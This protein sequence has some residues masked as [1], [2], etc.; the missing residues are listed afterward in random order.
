MYITGLSGNEMYC[1]H[2]IGYQAGDIVIGNSVHSLGFLGS[3]T[4]GLKSIAGGEVSQF[5]E[6]IE[7]GRRTSYSRMEAEA[8]TKGGVGITGVRNELIFHS[9]N[10][11]F[12]SIGSSLHTE[13]HPETDKLNFSTS[14]DGQ[15]LFCQVDAGYE[16]LKFVFGNIAYSIGL[17]NSIMGSIKTL[18]KGEIKEYSDIFNTTRKTTLNRIIKEAKEHS[19]KANAVVGIRTNILPLGVSGFQEMVMIGT[20]AYNPYI[21]KDLNGGIVTSDLTCQE[22]WNL[23]KMGYAPVSLVLGTSVYSMGIV[24][25]LSSFFKSFTRGELPQYSKLIYDARENSI[26][27]ISRE[28]KSLGADDIVGVKTYVYNLGGGL[29]EFLA[30]GTAIKK[31]SGLST[32][33]DELIPQAIINDKDTFIN[34]AEFNVGIDLNNQSV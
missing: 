7:E 29:I 16:P 20:S 11:E 18:G 4:S 10:I 1:V 25:G 17:G 5:T 32:K 6:L 24:G 31:I 28:A 30:I 8:I 22:M 21:P 9:G 19:P 15:E 26:D 33:S 12:L 14:A 27:I 3:I 23:T 2:K 34:M 13:D